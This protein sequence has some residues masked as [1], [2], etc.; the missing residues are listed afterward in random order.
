VKCLEE[1]T[2]IITVANVREGVEGAK[3]HYRYSWDKALQNRV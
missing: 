1:P 2:H 3:T